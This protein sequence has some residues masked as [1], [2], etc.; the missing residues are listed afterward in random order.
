MIVPLLIQPEEVEV[1]MPR[2]RVSVADWAA[3][4]RRLSPKTTNLAGDWSH[5]YTPYAVE[6]MESLSDVGTRQVDVMKCSQ[7]AGTEMG[8]NFLG[9]IIEESPGP[10]LIEMPR[11]DDANRRVNTR[12][13]PMFES[14][15]GLLKH[16][17]GKIENI[18]TGKETILDTMILYIAWAG[19]AAAMADNPVCYVILDEVGKFPPRVG[20]EA[21]PISLIKD[22][23]TTFY[24]RSKLYC[25]STPV[26]EGDLIDREFQAGDKRQWWA[27]CPHCGM[28]HILVWKNVKLD[29]DTEGNLLHPDEYKTGEHSRYVCPAC[30]AIWSEQERWAAVTAGRW[31]PEGC[32]VEPDGRISGRIPA[33]SHRSYHITA[34]MLYPGFMTVARLA[35]KWSEASTALKAGDVGPMQNFINSSLGEPWKEADKQTDENKLKAHIGRCPAGMLPDGVK[36]IT[37]G[38][39]VQLDHMWAVVLAWGYMSEC[40]IVDYRRLETG[41][42]SDLANYELLTQFLQQSYPFR[43]RPERTLDIRKTAIDTNY[44]SDVVT[45]YCLSVGRMFDIVPVRG[46]DTVRNKLFRAVKSVVGKTGKTTITRYDIN[47]DATKDR[48]FRLLYESTTPGPGYLHLPADADGELLTHLASEEQRKLRIRGR[49][50]TAW[51]LKSSHTPNHLW[52]C[53]VYAS[54]AGEL[55]GVRTIRKE[56]IKP[57]VTPPPQK[58][59]AAGGFLD[60]LPELM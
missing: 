36:T 49:L 6:I 40:W 42:T 13:K 38:I 26:V 56:N 15:P 57:N 24:A 11:E 19:S 17:G 23:Q 30:G 50:I 12:I 7:S 5:E 10:T 46:D 53:T 18:N 14:T 43:D 33:T 25:I 32:V 2:D 37:A 16:V 39:D 45:D 31:A 60:N 29:R 4:S 55:A 41:D 20:K 51:M 48:L 35:A 28:Y 3:Q 52:D 21:D 9:W 58:K 59:K 34:L 44:Q 54:F 27:R 22:R 8:L 47:V 1:L